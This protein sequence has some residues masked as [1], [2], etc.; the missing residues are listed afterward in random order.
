VH[1]ALSYALVLLCCAFVFPCAARADEFAKRNNEGNELLKQGQ[2]DQALQRYNEAKVE[3]PDRPEVDYNIGNVYHLEGKLDS[4]AKEYQNALST[5]TGPIAPSAS[6]NLGNTFYRMQEY[7]PA[8]E[9]YKRAL[10]ENPGDLDAKHNLELALRRLQADSTQQQQQQK[11]QQNKSDSTQQ[12][13]D[14]KKDNPNDQQKKDSTQQNQQSPQDKKPDSTQGQP[15]P[16]GQ[17]DQQPGDQKKQQAPKPVGMTKEDAKRLL[18]ALKNDE[19]KVQ[20]LRAQHPASEVPV[21]KDW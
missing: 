14:Q 12:E 17:E 10:I 1:R 15:P 11:D 3:R 6:Y 8:I 2:L 19:L 9:A 4:A 5:L 18:D 16:S 20:R 13:Q 7:R 21:I